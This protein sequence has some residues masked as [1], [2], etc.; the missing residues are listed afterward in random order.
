MESLYSSSQNSTRANSSH[1]PLALSKPTRSRSTRTHLVRFDHFTFRDIS[2]YPDETEAILV[3]PAHVTYVEDATWGLGDPQTFI[4]VSG[5]KDSFCV[6]G[7]LAEVQRKL[8][9]E[10]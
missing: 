2:N 3:N 5:R 8:N 1:P 9:G 10:A 6:I 4:H 7:S